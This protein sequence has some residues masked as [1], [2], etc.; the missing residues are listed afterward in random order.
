MHVFE[1]PFYNDIRLRFQRLFT[2]GCCFA[3]EDPDLT[4]WNVELSDRGMRR[5]MNGNGSNTFWTDLAD[6]LLMCKKK[7]LDHL[8]DSALL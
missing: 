5:F 6:F 2:N 1:C 4:I 7:K 8:A 3:S